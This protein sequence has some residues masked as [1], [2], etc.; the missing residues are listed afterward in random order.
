MNPLEPASLQPDK[1]PSP[2]PKTAGNE[3]LQTPKTASENTA[4]VQTPKEK[5]LDSAIEGTPSH[6]AP[7][8]SFQGVSP[9]PPATA[10]VAIA[11][12]TMKSLPDKIIALRSRAE[13]LQ[14]TIGPMR[15]A[16]IQKKLLELTNAVRNADP[17]AVDLFKELDKKIAGL[18]SVDAE[19]RMTRADIARI[20]ADQLTNGAVKQVWE[21]KGVNSQVYYTARNGNSG[22]EKELREETTKMLTIH[23]NLHKKVLNDFIKNEIYPFLAEAAYLYLDDFPSVAAVK[24]AVEKD[25][26]RFPPEVL[27]S[28]K[29]YFA[30]P[31]G[32][33]ETLEAMQR[34]QHLAVNAQVLT[35]TECINGQYTVAVDRADG[36]LEALLKNPEW[37]TPADLIDIMSQVLSGMRDLHEAGYTHG[38]LKPENVL[39]TFKDGK[40]HVK[41]SDFGKAK[42][43]GAGANEAYMGNTRFA[44]PENRLSFPGDVYG[45]GI[46]LIRILEQHLLMS[47]GD[48]RPKPLIEP[49][50]RGMSHAAH[51]S[52]KTRWGYEIYA[53]ES[54]DFNAVEA[55]HSHKQAIRSRVLQGW[56]HFVATSPEDLRKMQIANDLYMNALEARLKAEGFARPEDVG[57]ICILIRAMI[58]VNKNERPSMSQAYDAFKRVTQRAEPRR[59]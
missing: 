26:K 42:P 29:A 48:T 55:N 49:E 17:K 16:K 31:Q 22:A 39:V 14:P 30:S 43:L 36:D 10:E 27:S 13:A 46:K 1:L 45:T 41:I 24:E 32:Q 58:N 2:P 47:G 35:G 9:S 21:K 37:Y 8:E 18:A 44:P 28:L 56:N 3:P 40:W 5:M 59:R 12:V 57:N 52:E 25:D 6:K 4:A 15:Y 23:N 53:I 33:Q 7:R 11:T 20:P 50:H 19:N 51:N 38:D 54:S 34:G